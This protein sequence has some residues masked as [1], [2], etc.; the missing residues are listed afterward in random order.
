[1]AEE[2]RRQQIMITYLQYSNSSAESD[3]ISQKIL[4]KVILSYHLNN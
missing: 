3:D 2:S 1:M 4:Y